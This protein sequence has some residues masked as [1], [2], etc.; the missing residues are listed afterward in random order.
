MLRHTTLRLSRRNARELLSRTYATAV[1]SSSSHYDTIV[2][3]GGHAGVEAAHAS[4][5]TGA[6][7]L[8]LTAS[9]NSIGEL[10]CNPSLG[11]I[12]K[13]TLVR[14]VDA[15]DGLCGLV[16]DR[17]GVQF[18]LLNRSK[19]PA[20]YGPRAQLDR[21]LYRR[22]MQD[23]VRQAAFDVRE[24]HVHGLV[25]RDG[26]VVGVTTAQ[27]DIFPCSQAIL[28][29]GTFLRATIHIGL[30]ARPAG[31]M[32]PLPSNRDEPAAMGISECLAQAGFTLGRLK[33]GTPARIDANTVDL[34]AP[35]QKDRNVHPSFEILHGD[36]Q[37]APF[38][39]LNDAPSI[40][41][42]D[43]IH[44]WGLR[45]TPKTHDIVVR[46]SCILTLVLARVWY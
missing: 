33:T 1:P 27:G 8:L 14:E 19:G 23:A 41:P 22:E 3:G 12:G 4:S 36:Q 34:G 16:G 37:P 13:G 35:W 28:A 38:S 15:L 5:R 26:T 31:R 20:V 45:T 6:R 25:I 21:A 40:D 44:C 32:Q 30:E 39:F 24:A 29:T 42:E 18:R 2:I 43:Q 11:G 46:V 10:S 7:T 17:A 9:F